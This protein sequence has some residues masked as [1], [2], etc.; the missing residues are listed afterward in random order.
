MKLIFVYNADTGFFNLV[1]DIAHK[2]FSPQ[3]YPCS[4]C[5]LTHNPLKMKAE[6]RDFLETLPLEKAFYHRDD[7]AGAFPEITVDLPAILLSKAGQETP[8]VL[9]DARRLNGMRDPGELMAAL[10]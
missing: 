6:W 4:L 3:T 7:F 9:L 5:A 2:L 1:A 10:G 8:S